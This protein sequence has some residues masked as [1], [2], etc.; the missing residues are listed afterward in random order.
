MTVSIHK[1]RDAHSTNNLLAI[2]GEACLELLTGEEDAALHG[3]EG[4]IHLLGDF[5]VLVAGDVHL[6][7]YA[8]LFGEFVDV[9]ENLACLE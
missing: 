2:V 8:V 3:T 4:K 5:V 9:V 6:E 1:Q 7:G